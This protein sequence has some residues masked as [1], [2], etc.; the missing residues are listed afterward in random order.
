VLVQAPGGVTFAALATGLDHSCGLATSGAV[1]CWGYNAFGQLGDNTTVDKPTP[2]QAGA[3][4]AVTFA[5]VEAGY[6]HT[7]AVTSAG[8]AYCWGGNGNAQ[9]GDN[10]T[11][12]KLVPTAVQGGVVFAVV[13]G[14]GNHTCGVSTSGIGYCWGAN[15]SGQIGDNTTL[16]KLAPAVTAGSLSLSVAAAG[17]NHSCAVAA[18]ASASVYCWG[19]NDHGELGDGTTV[20][21]LVPTRVLR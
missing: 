1:Y 7:C 21:R 11:V 17:L 6:A 2:V 16:A 5:T 18:G 14:G 19:A 12:D 20:P 15:G 13:S 8:A 4:A 10:T 3:P 9:L